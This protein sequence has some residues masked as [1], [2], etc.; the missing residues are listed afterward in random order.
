MIGFKINNDGDVVIADGQIQIV[1]DKELIVQK[2]KQ[3]IE[4]NLGEWEY[5]EREGID[6][7]AI[8]AKNPLPEQV[9]ENILSALQQVDVT[10]RITSFS[11]EK[12]KESRHL[13][14]SFTAINDS[15]V[16]ISLDL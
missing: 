6:R 16:E 11:C 12:D 1:S 15:D 3:L 13:S 2:V 4:T 8:L 7:Y 14:I 9:E 5:D 10:F